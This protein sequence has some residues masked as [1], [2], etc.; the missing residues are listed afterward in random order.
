ME[1]FKTLLILMVVVWVMGKVF[2]AISLPVV[3]G[4]LVGGIIV[5]PLMLNLVD[6]DSVTIKVLAE[7]GIFFLMLHAGLETD[8]YKLLKTSRKSGLI[9][10]GGFILPFILG[11]A[12]ARW[13]GQS[14]NESVFIAIGVSM[15]AIAVS[16]RIL[17]DYKI[18]NSETAN[19]I[20][21][22]A[23]LTDIIGLI[24]L[25]I[26]LD[27]VEKG[28]VD[29]ATISIF[30]VKIVLFF[31]IVIAGGF[32]TAKYFNKLF[33]DKGFTLTLIIAMAL[34]LLAESMGLHMIIGAFLAGLFIRE[35][36]ID[37]KI[38][39]KI[40]D[41]IYGLSYSFPGPIFFTSLAFYLDFTSIYSRPSFLISIIIIA[42]IGKI[43]GSGIMAYIQ[44]LNFKRSLLIG[45]ALNGRGAVELVIASI[46]LQ[47]G[48]IQKDVFSI[49]VIMA[50]VTTLISIIG[51]KPMAKYAH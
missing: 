8:P 5:G 38:F 42:I 34:G 45:L 36:V 27:I 4:E 7:L 39:N 40:E 18:Q 51:M 33:F 49:L 24:S 29:L 46:G 15:T 3:F 2:R 20:L 23:I 16:V 44:K 11:Y 14:V 21:G 25:S 32:L 10:I 47:Q 41:H 35:E 30:L 28:S 37:K 26:M 17:K 43:I 12:T 50:F 6:P 9:A 22:T 31:I 19:I 1:E 13:F 48:I